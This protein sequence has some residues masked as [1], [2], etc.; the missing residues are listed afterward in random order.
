MTARTRS[1]AGAKA[2]GSLMGEIRSN[3]QDAYAK[4]GRGAQPEMILVRLRQ[5][6]V[7]VS[8]KGPSSPPKRGCLRAYPGRP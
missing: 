6:E 8:A 4:R 5:K 2:G 7:V 3:E 1:S